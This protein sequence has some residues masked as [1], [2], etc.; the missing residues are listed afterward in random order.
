MPEII[1]GT[2]ISRPAEKND[3][4]TVMGQRPEA[5]LNREAEIRLKKLVGVPMV[6]PKDALI[7]MAIWRRK[8]NLISLLMALAVAAIPV[9]VSGPL[10]EIPLALQAAGSP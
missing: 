7:A 10:E 5:S 9:V 6:T 1:V 2:T 8:K 3:Q 4:H